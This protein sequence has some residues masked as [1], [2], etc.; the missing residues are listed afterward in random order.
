[1]VAVAG[2]ARH[3]MKAARRYRAVNPKGPIEVREFIKELDSVSQAPYESD[4]QNVVPAA[5]TDQLNEDELA[6]LLSLSAKP[7]GT[8]GFSTERRT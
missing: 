6:G 4:S 2:E 1:M 8:E 3:L 5:Y 7:K